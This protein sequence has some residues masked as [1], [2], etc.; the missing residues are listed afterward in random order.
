MTALS[1]SNLQG[2]PVGCNASLLGTTNIDG[3][4]LIDYQGNTHLHDVCKNGNEEEVKRILASENRGH[5]NLEAR[6]FAGYTPLMVALENGRDKIAELLIAAGA[7]QSFAF[8]SFICEASPS[9]QVETKV[10]VV[11]ENLM[12]KV[13]FFGGNTR[14]HQLCEEGKEDTLR[15]QLQLN[16]ENI[17]LEVKNSDGYTPL[18]VAVEKGH[19]KIALMLLEAGA[20]VNA[21][22]KTG[23]SVLHIAAKNGPDHQMYE[24]DQY[25]KFFLAQG[26]KITKEKGGVTIL[27]AAALGGHLSEELTRLLIR[28]GDDP[29]AVFTVDSTYT[30][31]YFMPGTDSL[32]LLGKINLYHCLATH[33]DNYQAIKIL[34]SLKPPVEP[35]LQSE[36][37]QKT[38]IYIASGLHQPECV[39]EL[40]KVGADPKI[41]NNRDSALH[42]ACIRG[43]CLDIITELLNQGCDP[44]YTEFWAQPTP[45]TEFALK[46]LTTTDDEPGKVLALARLFLEKKGV[47]D[48]T[49]F[50]G[51]H[52]YITR[53]KREDNPDIPGLRALNDFVK[54]HDPNYFKY[55][56]HPDLS[57]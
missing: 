19:Q 54:E 21:S 6:N 41:V 18:M 50:N 55:D 57:K 46:G 25:V 45:F 40:L 27:A 24:H 22:T 28:A 5:L 29:Y 23:W 13:G 8:Q 30:E 56:Q 11:A 49:V 51:F 34:G 36:F 3:M 17:N 20:N 47:F 12:R 53:K 7:K 39:R 31:K 42:R 37:Q 52:D 10:K 43:T 1:T 16:R 15:V 4:Y 44:N 26:A 2:S 33:I 35:N 38:P 14:L 9:V 32:C 48:N